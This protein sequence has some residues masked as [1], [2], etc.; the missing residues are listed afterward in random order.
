VSFTDPNTVADPSTGT[1]ATA[2]L[3]NQWRTD[4]EFLRNTKAGCRA[5]TNVATVLGVNAVVPFELEDFDNNTCH[6]LVTNNS[7]ITVPTGWGGMWQFGAMIWTTAGSIVFRIIKN[8]VTAD[9][10][11]LARTIS[12]TTGAATTIARLS[13]FSR[14]SAGD[15]VEVLCVTGATLQVSFNPVFW[16]EWCRP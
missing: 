8:G 4:Q 11:A 12:E 3:L 2:A 15:Y 16:A 13:G 14:L 5:R 1:K 7:R 10:S 6:D 9:A